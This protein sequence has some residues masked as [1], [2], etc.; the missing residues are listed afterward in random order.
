LR[1]SS[2]VGRGRELENVHRLLQ[3]YRL[4]TLAG[5]GGVGKTRLALELT[6]QLMHAFDSGVWL[7]EL[8][9]VVHYEAVARA[10]AH[11]L[12]VR[13]SPAEPLARSIAAALADQRILVILD[14]CEHLLVPCAQLADHLLRA[15]PGLHILATSREPLEVEGE[16]VWRVAPL[17][18]PDPAC[19]LEFHQVEQ[20]P[21]VQLFVQRAEAVEPAFQLTPTNA[22]AVANICWQ[23]DGLPLAL[24]LA[25]SRIRALSPDQ[26]AEHLADRFA[27]LAGGARIAPPRHQTLRSAIAWSHELLSGPERVLFRRLSVFAG[28]WTLEAA[29]R[30]CTGDEIR[31]ADVLDLLTSLVSKSLVLAEQQPGGAVRFRMLETIRQFAADALAS[32][33]EKARYARRS[34]EYFVELACEVEAVY[35]T[36][37]N[38]DRLTGLRPDWANFDA[39][40]YSIGPLQRLRL[41]VALHLPRYLLEA[42]H[43]ESRDRLLASLGAAPDAPA[44]L[45]ARALIFLA[46]VHMLL[47]DADSAEAYLARSAEMRR[48]ADATGGLF[49]AMRLSVAVQSGRM[50]HA[51]DYANDALSHA[52]RPDVTLWSRLVI[53]LYC[54]VIRA[55]NGKLADADRL[56]NAALALCQGPGTAH[57]RGYALFMFGRAQAAA[58]DFEAA[59]DTTDR[60]LQALELAHDRSLILGALNLRGQVAEQLE[61]FSAARAMYARGLRIVRARGSR[62]FNTP[63]LLVGLAGVSL[64]AGESQRAVLFLAALHLYIASSLTMASRDVPARSEQLLADLKLRLSDAEFQSAWSQ[65][66]NMDLAALADLA[67]EAPETPPRGEVGPAPTVHLTDRQLGVLKL[68]VQ[69]QSNRE[70]ARALQL[71]EKTVG[72]HLEN[73][74][75]RLGVSSRTAAAAWAVRAGLD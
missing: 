47:G 23:L 9:P 54:G 73:L 44:A 69:G 64:H 74:F 52:E 67:A 59:A 26:I 27:L 3:Q 12:A 49:H 63:G 30:T 61:D 35:E 60:A 21:A 4:V 65:G 2:Y 32:D 75:D 15:C 11:A 24:E 55:S 41:A 20:N 48:A 19:S 46:H 57:M 38:H 7:V 39:A 16:H 62:S 56:F 66:Q 22:A 28:G 25:A 71:S 18:A 13:E 17:P 51:T 50:E 10:V 68:V 36:T 72:R 33:G 43:L 34:A 31:Q 29:E 42:R 70:I 58:H 37:L 14:N 53:L 45:R 5:V 8:A 1:L 6:G 40:W